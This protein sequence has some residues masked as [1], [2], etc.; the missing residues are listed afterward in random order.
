MSEPGHHTGP[1]QKRVG[2]LAG[3]AV[4]GAC[5]AASASKGGPRPPKSREAPSMDGSTFASVDGGTPATETAVRPPPS[6]DVERILDVIADKA[7]YPLLLD[8]AARKLIQVA[9]LHRES[10]TPSVVLMVGSGQA[11]RRM[12]ITYIKTEQQTWEFSNLATILTA[13]SPAQV[14]AP[15]ALAYSADG[16]LYIG[17]GDGKVYAIGEAKP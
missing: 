1:G 10:P 5:I 17:A 11:V 15:V 2:V 4:L 9:D 16:T 13:G 6:P 12:E 3:V 8:D 14:P 7:M